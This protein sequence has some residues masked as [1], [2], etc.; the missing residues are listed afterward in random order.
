[1]RLLLLILSL[2]LTRPGQAQERVRNVRLHVADSSALEIQYDL[3]NA[4]PGDSIY[5]E[6]RS[7]LRGAL[8]IGPEFVRGDV[9]KRIVAGSDRR[10]VWNALANGYSLNEEIRATVLV[11]TGLPAAPD[12]PRPAES[13]AMA[14]PNPSPD[15]ATPDV[16][17]RPKRDEPTATPRPT[18]TDVAAPAVQ[19]PISEPSTRADVV[20]PDTVVTQKRRYAGPAW[21]LLSAVAPGF[22]NIFVQTPRPRIGL[23]PLLAVSCYGLLVYGL[24]ER[25]KSRD[26]YVVYQEQK[27][28]ETGEP[29]Y[30]TAND[31]HHRYYLATR[32]A[33]VIAAADVI[34]TFFKGLRNSRTVAANR[35]LQSVTLR[36]GL[37]AG[38][39]TAMVRYSF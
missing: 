10:I 19:P 24:Q 13:V 5:L 28:V 23:R 32:G 6:V 8:R 12:P 7:R 15:R 11:K 9:G 18:P 27:N 36:P 17:E 2:L 25:Q 37:Q 38:Q 26:A 33:I 14:Q 16:V 1:M 22:G 29:Y 31:L 20:Q 35:P 4:R 39:P 30:Q 34:L 21:A 3:I